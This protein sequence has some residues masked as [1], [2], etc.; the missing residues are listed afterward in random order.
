[1]LRLLNHLTYTLNNCDPGNK[2][3]THFVLA[4]TMELGTRSSLSATPASASD[5]SRCYPQLFG[6]FFSSAVARRLTVSVRSRRQGAFM[7]FLHA[8]QNESMSSRETGRPAQCLKPGRFCV[9][10]E[11]LDMYVTEVDALT[12]R[13]SRSTSLSWTRVTRGT[14]NNAHSWW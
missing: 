9:Q 8:S 7:N 10:R 4:A 11:G 3:T 14:V 2:R 12:S 5:T 6:T 1:M 13:F